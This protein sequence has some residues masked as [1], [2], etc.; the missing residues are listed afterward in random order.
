MEK[1]E[2]DDGDN[3]IFEGEYFD[4]KDGKDKNMT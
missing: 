2:Y 3:L 1:K 4:E